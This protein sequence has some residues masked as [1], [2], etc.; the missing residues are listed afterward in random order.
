V[1]QTLPPDREEKE[2]ERVQQRRGHCGFQIEL[3]RFASLI[4][5]TFDGELSQTSST[6]L[7]F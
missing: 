4:I 5:F 1:L 2:S 7:G 3:R 6:R